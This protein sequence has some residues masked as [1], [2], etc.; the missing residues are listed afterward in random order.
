MK[1]L[2]SFC[3]LLANATLIVLIAINIWM[4][5]VFNTSYPSFSSEKRTLIVSGGETAYDIAEKLENMGVIDDYFYFV[6]FCKVTG[7]AEKLKAGEYIIPPYSTINSI[8]SAIRAG[9]VFRR[10]ITIAEGLTSYEV[11][12]IINENPYLTGDFIDSPPE[13]TILPETYSYARGENRKEILL[14]MK[15]AMNEKLS[16]LWEYR[17]SDIPISSPY[18]ALI[19]AS[20]VEKES[21]YADKKSKIAG[22]FIN[23]L[24]VDMPLQADPTVIYALTEGKHENDGKGPI[25]RRLLRKDLQIDS[26]YNTYMYKGLPPTPIANP[27][28]EAITS[29]LHPDRHD[30]YYFVANGQGGHEFASTLSEHNL[31]V[32]KWREIRSSR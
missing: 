14:R 13:G 22:V 11:A 4:H 28:I 10:Y 27:G 1:F 25:G 8:V 15:K 7:S 12:K 21:G 26:P 9:E 20:I 31:N 23:R 18:E 29:V 32:Q 19:L 5:N 30:Y 2:V 17:S 6:L 24:E 16:S 3:S